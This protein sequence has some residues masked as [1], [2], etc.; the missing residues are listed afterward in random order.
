MTI[1]TVGG[2]AIRA[3]VVARG[4]TFPVAIDVPLWG[5]G[6]VAVVRKILGRVGAR[7]RRILAGEI[8]D[9]IVAD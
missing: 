8:P 1:T 5:R 2:G 3:E 6:E 9:A 4:R 7:D